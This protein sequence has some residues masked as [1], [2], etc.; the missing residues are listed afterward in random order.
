[1]SQSPP[2]SEAPEAPAELD[3]GTDETAGSSA[4]VERMVEALLF[5]SAEPLSTRELAKALPDGC[6]VKAALAALVERYA[7]RG[8]VLRRT[9]DQWAFRTAPNLAWL[10]ERDVVRERKLSRAAMETLAII[11][12]H[13]PVTRIEIEEI[14]GVAVSRGT[15]N[16]LMEMGWVGLGRRRHAPGR[17]VTYVVTSEFMDHFG[18]ESLRDLPGMQELKALGL[19]ERPSVAAAN[20]TAAQSAEATENENNGEDD[21]ET[22][23]DAEA[24]DDEEIS[25]AD[26]NEDE[27]EDEEAGDAEED[28]A[29]DGEDG[30]SSDDGR[31]ES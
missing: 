23:G 22:S 5:A 30:E 29:A 14:R 6:D 18:L 3:A 15:V 21:V 20:A 4:E 31:D 9:D 8:V 24:D 27:D 19:L 13:Q 1:M 17:P 11:A 2:D 12:Y 16:T 7:D 10:F 26:E 28:D 25:D